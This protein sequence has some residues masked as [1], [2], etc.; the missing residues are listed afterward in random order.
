MK[1]YLKKERKKT[2]PVERVW[3]IFMLF[4]HLLTVVLSTKLRTTN[5]VEINAINNTVSKISYTRKHELGIIGKNNI[6]AKLAQMTPL[7]KLEMAEVLLDYFS[8]QKDAE[9]ATISEYDYLTIDGLSKKM[10]YNKKNCQYYIDLVDFVVKKKP[11]S[12]IQYRYRALNKALK[13]IEEIRCKKMIIDSFIPMLLVK[14]FIRKIV[15]ESRLN[16]DGLGWV[17]I[18]TETYKIA[19]TITH[20]LHDALSK[21]VGKPLPSIKVSLVN[22]HGSTIQT[23]LSWA[24]A[25]TIKEISIRHSNTK[26][27]NFQK[28]NIA[29]NYSIR[30]CNV[31]KIARIVLPEMKKEQPMQ[32][33]TQK[34]S[35]A[36]DL[37]IIEK[38]LYL[39]RATFKSLVTAHKAAKLI[40]EILQ[41]KNLYLDYEPYTF[42]EISAIDCSSW[43][44]TKHLII[45]IEFCTACNIHIKDLI[46][47]N[48]LL[49]AVKSMGI[50]YTKMFLDKN[51]TGIFRKC[52]RKYIFTYNFI[53]AITNMHF[54]ENISTRY[55]C[56]HINYS[57]SSFYIYMKDFQKIQETISKFQENYDMTTVFVQYESVHIY[58]YKSKLAKNDS[59]LLESIFKCMGPRIKINILDFYDME[60][61]D[62]SN[63]QKQESM[64]SIVPKTMFILACLR[65]HNSQAS[66]ILAMLNKYKYAPKC[67]VYIYCKDIKKEN[68]WKI[69]QEILKH[70]FTSIYIEDRSDIIMEAQKT[71]Y[72]SKYMNNNNLSIPKSDLRWLLHYPLFLKLVFQEEEPT[73]SLAYLSQLIVKQKKTQQQ[74]VCSTPSES[75]IH[76]RLMCYSVAEACNQLS[77]FSEKIFFITHLEIL[78]YTPAQSSFTT[79]VDLVRLIMTIKDIFVYVEELVLFNLRIKE[80]E[81]KLVTAILDAHIYVR[82]R[83]SLTA[84]YMDGYVLVDGQGVNISK[85]RK[86]Y[87]ATDS[88]S[89]LLESEDMYIWDF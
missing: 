2:Y 86:N 8:I 1:I 22:C 88:I 54:Q 10:E 89:L 27:L 79:F 32:P 51:R 23:I 70:Q 49:K 66:F 3:K 50:G 82:K 68:I 43:I 15:V 36:S 17:N 76:H 30:L 31:S 13:G 87:I 41:V 56:S 83:H 63:T 25:Y 4:M 38:S 5:S 44:Q 12:P 84:I 64:S 57:I 65:F 80:E 69:C 48:R 55:F 21:F 62:I 71:D 11:Y 52:S 74:D 39:D 18:P 9:C 34:D 14:V 81:E 46:V 28:V 42:Q 58:G 53:V 35:I 60:G 75:I 85:E 7:N 24:A 20:S 16:I 37:N 29:Q 40:K 45:H 61:R 6:E 73:F 19:N 59:N 67:R 78:I 47:Q 33:I 26:S 77:D 72:P